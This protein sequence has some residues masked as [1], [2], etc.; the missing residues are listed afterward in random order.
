MFAIELESQESS[1]DMTGSLTEAVGRIVIGDFV[2]SFRVPL[3]FWSESDYRRSWHQAFDALKGDLN[4]RSCLMVSMTDPESSNFLT[5]WPMYRDGENVYI[6]NA[7][8][9]LDELES[10]FDIGEPWA[11]IGP[12]CAIDEDGNKISEWVAPMDSVRDFFE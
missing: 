2:E 6:Q 1:G 8:I 5:C 7:I 10:S 12:R 4:A 3:G 9:F 11:S